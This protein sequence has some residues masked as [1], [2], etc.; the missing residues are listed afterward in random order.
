[1][2]AEFIYYMKKRIDA[3]I[4]QEK[5]EEKYKDYSRPKMLMLSGHETTISLHE[6]FLMDALGFDKD[7][8]IFPKFASQVTFEV[9]TKNDSFKKDNYS[10]YYINYYFDDNL[11]FNMTVPE[12]IEK[13]ESHIWSS[14]KINKYCGL[15]EEIIVINANKTNNGD[16]KAKKAYK[17]LMIIF[18]ILSVIF[19]AFSIFL[20]I[21]LH[22]K[23]TIVLSKSC[24]SQK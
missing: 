5:I 12:F 20:W 3:D 21:Q 11:I 1:M 14:E 10:D 19:L 15:N 6:V 24:V 2:M 16:D 22:K 4:N 9:T 13:I 8:F 17:I 23:N 18:I 7:F